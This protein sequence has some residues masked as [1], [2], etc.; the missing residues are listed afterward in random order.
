MVRVGCGLVHFAH[1]GAPLE[2]RA[3]QPRFH[4]QRQEQGAQGTSQD[5]SPAAAGQKGRVP[6]TPIHHNGIGLDLDGDVCSRP[7]S[8]A[9]RSMLGTVGTAMSPQRNT[10]VP[11][12]NKRPA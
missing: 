1:G 3:A 9:N 5:L 11:E 2:R 10:A 12:L 8:L 7:G 4:L 6:R